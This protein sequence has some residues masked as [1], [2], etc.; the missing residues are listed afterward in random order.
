[1]KHSETDGPTNALTCVFCNQPLEANARD[2]RWTLGNNPAPAADHGK[3][4]DRCNR[5]AVI[6]ARLTHWD[7]F[8]VAEENS[9]ANRRTAER[10][11]FLAEVVVTA[12]ESGVHYWAELSEY[13]WDDD[14]KGEITDASF[15]VRGFDGDI[16]NDVGSVDRA[17][18]WQ[19][20]DLDTIE[21]GIEAL[22]DPGFQVNPRIQ[23]EIFA[24][25]RVNDAGMIDANGADVIV[26]AAVFGEIIYG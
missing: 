19:L 24:G 6:P 14:G 20:V 21:R 16:P 10:S 17:L 9:R 25:E 11:S 4:C 1:M 12:A 26:Q 8:G 22:R 5:T 18:E 2:P 7:T 23:A 3:A 15:R 13:D